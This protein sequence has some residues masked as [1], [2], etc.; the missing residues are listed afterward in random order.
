VRRAV[1]RARQAVARPGR[2]LI[3]RRGLT[4]GPG[5]IGYERRYAIHSAET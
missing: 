2:L 1:G 4:I 3:A 5:L